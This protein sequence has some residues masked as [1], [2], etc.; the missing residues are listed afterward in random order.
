[1][2]NLKGKSGLSIHQDTVQKTQPFMGL[3][4][5]F[6]IVVGGGVCVMHVCLGEGG[7]GEKY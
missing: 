5:V 2:P 4:P 7:E 6:M 1:M 3:L